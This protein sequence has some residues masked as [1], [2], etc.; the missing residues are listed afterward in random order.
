M[1]LDKWNRFLKKWLTSN[2]F[3]TKVIG[4][5]VSHNGYSCSVY[6]ACIC[7]VWAF[8][9]GEFILPSDKMSLKNNKNSCMI[10]ISYP[11]KLL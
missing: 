3:V 2:I 8:I 11:I 1:S 6:S 7:Q 9:K 4:V 10:V 5:K